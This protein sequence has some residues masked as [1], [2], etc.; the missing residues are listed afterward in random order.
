FSDAMAS[1]VPP[2]VEETHTKILGW[3]TDILSV[4]FPSA[5]DATTKDVVPHT[6]LIM[7]PGNPG[8]YN[9][10]TSD[11]VK[12]VQRLGHGF[13]A[14]ALS[15][16][17]HSLGGKEGIVDVQDY[18]RRNSN[19]DPAVPWTIEGQ[20]RHKIAF[21]DALMAEWSNHNTQNPPNFIFL[22]HSF[23]CYVIQR[24]CVQRK[25]ILD[26]TL[27]FLHLMPFIRM[28]AH[29]FDQRK[30]DLGAY[31][32]QALITL[33]TAVSKTYKALPK[34]WVDTF[35]KMGIHDDKTRDIALQILR[36]P[37]FIKNF[38]MLGTEEIRDIPRD[39][40]VSAG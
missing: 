31:N 21:I 13:A 39:I 2:Q 5:S 37:K 18:A 32:P 35:V 28:K 1:E 22:G 6:V 40:D 7:I 3:P 10:Y 25:E 34:S 19:A 14:R 4:D 27:G 26:R 20:V 29:S 17:G 9:W 30:L 15:H 23:G 36:D 12:L 8:Q 11:L 16:A 33:G 38:F 24:I